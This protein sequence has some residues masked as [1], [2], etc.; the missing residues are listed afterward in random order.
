MAFAR[1]GRQ[2]KMTR[3]TYRTLDRVLHEETDAI[4]SVTGLL[5]TATLNNGPHLTV[6]D[7]VHGRGV[8]CVLDK[9]TLRQAG[10]WLGERVT[11]IGHIRRDYLGRPEQVRNAKIEPLPEQRR[12]TVAEMGGAFEGGP[13]SIEWLREQ[14]GR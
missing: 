6:K 12:V 10:Q 7:D 11:V 14:R 2:R 8:R 1:D 3:R 5:V 13:D 4:G 9:Q